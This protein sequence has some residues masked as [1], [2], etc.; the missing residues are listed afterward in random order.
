MFSQHSFENKIKIQNEETLKYDKYLT[1]S[2]E[3]K[4]MLSKLN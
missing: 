2:S 4:L 1:V 3:M